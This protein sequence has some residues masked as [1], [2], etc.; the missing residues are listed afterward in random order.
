MSNKFCF[1]FGILNALNVFEIYVFYI[2]LVGHGQ[3]RTAVLDL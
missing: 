1:N 2:N 3:D